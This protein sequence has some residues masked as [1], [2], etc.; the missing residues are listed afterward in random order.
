MHFDSNIGKQF[1]E[2]SIQK[3]FKRLNGVE[4]MLFGQILV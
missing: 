3:K 1:G 2:V 4:L